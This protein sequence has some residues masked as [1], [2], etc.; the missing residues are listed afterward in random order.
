M[1]YLNIKSPNNKKKRIGEEKKTVLI[2]NSHRH[3]IKWGGAQDVGNYFKYFSA[4]KCQTVWDSYGEFIHWFGRPNRY[5][6]KLTRA[7]V[8]QG[9]V[10][11]KVMCNNNTIYY[12]VISYF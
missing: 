4:L 2:N 6:I 5:A 11:G 9:R 7:E 1:W 10:A 12:L 3:E 8:Q